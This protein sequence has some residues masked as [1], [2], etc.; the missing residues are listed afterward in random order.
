MTDNSPLGKLYNRTQ[1]LKK[2]RM[3][4]N[5]CLSCGAYSSKNIEVQFKRFEELGVPQWEQDIIR[6]A[7]DYKTQEAHVILKQLDNLIE[8]GLLRNEKRNKKD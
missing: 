3:I 4:T 6:K 1:K 5:E 7:W 8:G 2:I